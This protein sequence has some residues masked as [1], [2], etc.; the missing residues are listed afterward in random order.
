MLD[1]Y[2]REMVLRN[3][4]SFAGFTVKIVLRI[5]RRLIEIYSCVDFMTYISRIIT[6]SQLIFF[7]NLNP[8]TNSE[9]CDGP[10]I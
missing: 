10:K 7:L 3:I 4:S 9:T 5:V 6:D 2:V 8:A 1:V